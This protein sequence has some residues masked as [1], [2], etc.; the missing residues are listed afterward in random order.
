MMPVAVGNNL[1]MKKYIQI[2]IL[3]LTFSACGPNA[4]KMKTIE[5]TNEKFAEFIAKKKFVETPYPNF[6]PGIADEKKRPVLTEKINQAAYNTSTG[7]TKTK[8]ATFKA[9][10]H[11]F[12]IGILAF[13][14]IQL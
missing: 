14:T 2:F 6:Y 3:F 8:H 1:K 7:E 9:F 12:K 13:E 10:Y 11:S 4:T 5:N